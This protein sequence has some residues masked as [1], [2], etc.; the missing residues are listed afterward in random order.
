[1]ANVQKYFEAFHDT[2]R[3]D[4]DMNST[5]RDKRDK[6]LDLLKRRL[7]DAD[8]PLC[9][10]L[11]QGSY[12]M[13]TGVQP[14]ADLEYDLDL[15]LRFS[16]KVGQHKATEVRKWI[17]DAVDGHTDNVDEKGPCIRV[18]YSKGY[19]VDLVVYSTWSDESGVTQ[20]RLAHRDNGWRPADPPKHLQHVLDNRKRFEDTDDS[21]TKTDQFRRIVRYLKRWGD[22]AISTE[23][24]AKPTGIAY[25]LYAAE[26]LQPAHFWDGGADDR[27]ALYS[28]TQIA[29]NTFG[30][31]S[32]NKP[33]PEYDDVFSRLTDSEMNNLKTRFKNLSAALQKADQETDPVTACKG[34]RDVFGSDFPVPNPEHTGKKT[35]A[36]AIVTSA[37]SAQKVCA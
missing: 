17:F 30:R 29:A 7:K 13:G 14:I 9:D 28:L 31:I 21:K 37:S 18:G 15:G 36:P 24:S 27:S 23:S 12:R 32:V 26:L 11:L 19:H 35:S 10:E 1:M 20:Y 6:I 16:L 8:R 34:L 5:L 4:Y 22:V 3:A 25:T 2:I 33:T